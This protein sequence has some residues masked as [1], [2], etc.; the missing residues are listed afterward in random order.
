MSTATFK[1]ETYKKPLNISLLICGR[2]KPF[3]LH[4]CLYYIKPLCVYVCVCVYKHTP[5][6]LKVLRKYCFLLSLAQVFSNFI[7][8]QFPEGFVKTWTAGPY[9]QSCRFKNL[10]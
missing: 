4:S 9:L 8:C 1:G 7:L 5:G 10:G 6:I 2:R 3:V